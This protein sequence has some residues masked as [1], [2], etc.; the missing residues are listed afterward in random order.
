MGA[1]VGVIPKAAVAGGERRAARGQRSKG[2]GE[3]DALTGQR[4]LPREIGPEE[5]ERASGQ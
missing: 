2:E 3:V 1:F 5:N 4:S